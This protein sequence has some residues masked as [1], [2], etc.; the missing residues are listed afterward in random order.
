MS[1]NAINSVSHF[2]NEFFITFEKGRGALGK[3]RKVKKKGGWWVMKKEKKK[4]MEWR[5]RA[6]KWKK[7]KN[8]DVLSFMSY[9]A[10]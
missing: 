4:K 8:I 10:V 2:T 3:S 5:E 9:D 1:K 7:T 6:R